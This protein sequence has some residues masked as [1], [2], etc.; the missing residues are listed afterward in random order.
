MTDAQRLKPWLDCRL[1]AT[2]L[3]DLPP[4][5]RGKVRDNYDLGN[6]QRAIVSTDRLS[7]FDQVL[8]AIPCKGQVL[9]LAALFWFE[10]TR[11]ICPNHV[12][13]SPDP[14]VIVAR[15]LDMLPVEMVVRDYLAGSTDTSILTKYQ[16]GQR[17]MYGLTLPDGLR[18]NAKLP[19]TI[20]T[21]TT[22]A[23]LG[24]HDAELTPADIVGQGLLTQAQWL[25][26][27]GYSLRLFDRGRDL[28]ARSGLIL[29]DTKYEFGLDQAGQIVLAD[30]IH[31]PDSSR[32][33]DAATYPARLAE[34]RS[35]QSFDKDAVRRW[36][37]ASGCDPYR[38][39]IP[40]VPD[41]IVLQTAEV[42][43]EAFERITGQAFVLPAVESPLGRIRR[44]LQP[45]MPA[46]APAVS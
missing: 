39:A 31:T 7:A 26:M 43:I 23:A 11:D 37:K 22:K 2:D 18:S 4:P 12:L 6:G 36:V 30:E 5:Y 42:Y 25:A 44:N 3:P 35:P 46:T 19:A 21:P 17:Q 32:F 34:A 1:T 38:E 8:T 16:H 9:T 45:F 27:S 28:A 10:A 33:W 40:T 29:V 24:G 15:Q 20:I 41:D 13:H 14:N